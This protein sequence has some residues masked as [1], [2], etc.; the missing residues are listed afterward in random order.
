M[1]SLRVMFT[2]F[3]TIQAFESGTGC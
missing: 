2:W 3:S 1:T